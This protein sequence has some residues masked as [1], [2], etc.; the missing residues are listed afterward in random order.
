MEIPGAKNLGREDAAETLRV[1]V[2]D[3]VIVEHSCR[4]DYAAEW[5]HRSVD[6][7][8]RACQIG[9][10]RH[11]RLHGGGGGS[12]GRKLSSDFF[13]LRR[14]ATATEQGEMPRAFLDKPARDRK[15]KVS[16]TSGDQVRGVGSGRGRAPGPSPGV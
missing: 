2:E 1:H 3:Q 10:V 5:R 4:V 13:A 14:S 6:H 15:P 16:V 8:E 7:G 12:V 9:F 11:V